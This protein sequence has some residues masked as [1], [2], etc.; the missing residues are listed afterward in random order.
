MTIADRQVDTKSVPEFLVAISQMTPQPAS[1]ITRQSHIIKLV[2]SIQS[3]DALTTA[4]VASDYVLIL[5]QG[6]M[7]NV[8]QMLTHQ[9]SLLCHENVLLRLYLFCS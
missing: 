6:F 5:A 9:L 2:L 8:F 7:G 4:D 3:V 1:E